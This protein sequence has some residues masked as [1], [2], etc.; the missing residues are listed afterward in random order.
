MVVLMMWFVV[1]VLILPGIQFVGI[2]GCGGSNIPLCCPHPSA[3][4]EI[5]IFQ[6]FKT[7]QR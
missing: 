1:A 4:T 7:F 3:F 2:T 6:Q 5:G